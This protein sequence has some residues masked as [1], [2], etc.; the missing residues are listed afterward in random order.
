MKKLLGALITVMVLLPFNAGAVLISDNYF[1][2]DDHNYGDVIG[3]TDFFQIVSMD[4][5]ISGDRLNVSILTNYVNHVGLYN[6]ELGDLFIS[7]NG[8]HPYGTAPYLEDNWSKGEAWEYVFDVS[9]GNLYSVDPSVI[10]WS[11]APTGYIWRNGQEVLYNS[12]GQT[13]ATTGGSATINSGNHLYNLSINIA[14]VGALSS[15]DNLA[16]HWGMTCAND[17]IEGAPVPEP[18]TLLISALGLA[19]LGAWGRRRRGRTR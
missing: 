11:Y 8:W 12:N 1:G 3:N 9:N 2:A 6:T 19:G 4:V 10:I 16:F 5:S 17:V 14:G 7:T 18:A 15:L 13:P